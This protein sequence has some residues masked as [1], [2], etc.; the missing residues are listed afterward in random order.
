MKFITFLNEIY[1]KNRSQIPLK[2]RFLVFNFFSRAT[3]G[4]KPEN[5]LLILT[6]SEQK[7]SKK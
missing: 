1:F 3:L 5:A 2:N 6:K 7:Y 4:L